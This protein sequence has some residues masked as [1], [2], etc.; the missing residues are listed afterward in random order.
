MAQGGA[1]LDRK[2][3][4]EILLRIP[5]EG[6]EGFEPGKDFFAVV[7]RIHDLIV[8]RKTPRDPE[9]W[10]KDMVRLLGS[11]RGIWVGD[12]FRLLNAN[13]A[14]GIALFTHEG[15]RKE[16]YWHNGEIIFA[17]SNLKDDRLGESLVRAGKITLAQLEEASREIRPDNK[18]GKILV[19]RGWITPRELFL[20][21]RHQVE[22]I[23]W[24]LFDWPGRFVFYEGF[25]DPE[26][27]IALNLSTTKLIIEGIRRSRLWQG[28]SLETPEQEI[29]LELLVSPKEMSFT[30]EERQL[31]ALIARGATLRELMDRGGLGVLETYGVIHHLLERGVVA[32]KVVAPD[33]GVLRRKAETGG[34]LKVA[35]V[36]Q[37]LI[38]EI[39]SLLLRKIPQETMIVRFNTFFQT[40]PQELA[41]VFEG[42]VFRPDGT[43]DLAR[44]V[45]N[46]EGVPDARTRLVKGFHELL[47]FVLFET[48][49]H[50]SDADTQ[51]ITELIQN[52]EIF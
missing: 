11:T 23:V 37:N 10:H 29:F 14:T 25:K 7:Y 3:G 34:L 39:Q 5:L 38:R 8:L 47:Y 32:L 17:Q 27:V 9:A 50:L 42:V 15:I 28:V 19:E 36:Y 30:A 40:L 45:A 31:L 26:S 43:L 6:F 1:G 12:L 41:P 46:L 48:K 52:I 18:L 44:I 2:T 33:T 16:I 49:N 51:R 13:H 4:E 20:G 21:V 22:E 35:Q 24:S